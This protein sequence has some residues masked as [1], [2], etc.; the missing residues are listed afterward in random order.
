MNDCAKRA[1]INLQRIK[2]LGLINW[3]TVIIIQYYDDD[4]HNIIRCCYL[5]VCAE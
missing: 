2:G 4:G 5:F 3:R 1:I